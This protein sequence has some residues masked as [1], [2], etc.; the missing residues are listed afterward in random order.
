MKGHLYKRKR[1]DGKMRY[2]SK[3]S[4]IPCTFWVDYMIKGKRIR[5]CLGTTDLQTAKERWA[6]EQNEL[7]TITNEEQWLRKRIEEGDRCRAALFK[8]VHGNK[9]ASHP[10]VKKSPAPTVRKRVA[11]P[12]PRKKSAKT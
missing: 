1:E 5:R 3:D 8:L 12:L 9:K 4:D 2:V 6:E 10:P 11:K 7:R